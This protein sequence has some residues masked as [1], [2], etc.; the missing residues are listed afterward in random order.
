MRPLDGP[1][2]MRKV[3]VCVDG[4]PKVGKLW[5]N[6]GNRNQTEGK[7]SKTEIFEESSLSTERCKLRENKKV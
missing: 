4:D 1:G 6:N 3:T 5:K 7:D 2:V